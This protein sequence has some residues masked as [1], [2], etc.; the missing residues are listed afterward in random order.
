MGTFLVFILKSTSCLILFYL[1]YKLLLSKDTFHR[2]NR[3]ALLGVILFAVFVPLIQIVTD[4]PVGIQ[5]PVHNLEY[6]LQ[7]VQGQI[8]TD[9]A[10]SPLSFWITFLFWGYIGGSLFFLSRFLYSTYCIIRLIRSGERFRLEEG[11]SLIVTPLPI[12]PFSWMRFIVISRVD[13]E[14]SGREILIHEKAHIKA[15]HS[16][17]MLMVGLCVVFHWFNPAAWLL[18]QELQ[19]VHEFEADEC[20]LNE[21]VDAKKYQ[22]LLIKKAVGTQRFTSMANSFNHSK[23]KKRITMMLKQKSNPWGRLKYLYV[24]PLTAIAAVAF[25][26]PEISHELEM[27]SGAKVMEPP[28]ITQAKVDKK[29]DQD[30][31]SKL[32][33]KRVGISK[34]KR[35]QVAEKDTW[36]QEDVT[37]TIAMQNDAG[38][39]ALKVVGLRLVSLGNDNLNISPVKENEY[40][41]KLFIPS[42]SSPVNEL[43]VR[44]RGGKG[45]PVQGPLLIVDG[46][47]QPGKGLDQV[48]PDDIEAMSVMKD[49]SA[50]KKY[51]EKAKNGVILITTKRK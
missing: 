49:E 20:V 42:G 18:K 23:L 43:R 24:L 50:Q 11:T 17:D 41:K 7:R 16:L 10:T 14:E 15:G 35:I 45:S 33:G 5:A 31:K 37:A 6:L 8:E 32:K 40:N 9:T 26:R 30:E 44:F 4:K 2:F 12:N 46:I 34:N 38:K 36:P 47:E 21:G 51:G 27:I 25:A 39:E 28:V 29:V 1:F 3:L 19:N 22:L 48:S 13:M